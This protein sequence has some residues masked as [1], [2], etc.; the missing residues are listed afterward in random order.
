MSDVDRFL[1]KAL[2]HAGEEANSVFSH[3]VSVKV[4]TVVSFISFREVAYLLNFV[5]LQENLC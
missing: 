4:A 1:C 2:P 3:A 5:T